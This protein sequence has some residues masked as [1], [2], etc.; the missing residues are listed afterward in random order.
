MRPM[1]LDTNACVSHLSRAIQCPTFGY[2]DQTHGNAQAFFQLQKQLEQDFPRC[3]QTLTYRTV[4]T[5]SRLYRWAGKDGS[6]PP[7]LLMAHQDVVPISPGTQGDWVHPPFSGEIAE[8]CV[9]GRGAIDM[10]NTLIA[11]FE[12]MEYLIGQGFVPEQDV[13]LCTGHDEEIMDV[14]GSMAVAQLCRKEGMH[15]EFVLDE[16]GSFMD[17]AAFGAPGT[18]LASVCVYEKGYC[19]VRLTCQSEGGHSS[20]PAETTALGDM[21]RALNALEQTKFP[22]RATQTLLDL[23]RIL[24]PCCEPQTRRMAQQPEVYGQ[25]LAEQLARSG[26]YGNAMVRTTT[27]VTQIGASEAPNVLP[28]RVWANVNFRLNAGDTVEG[29]RRFVE[30][31]VGPQFEIELPIAWNPTRQARVDARGYRLLAKTLQTF[32]PDAVVA[33]MAFFGGTDSRCFDDLADDVYK[34]MPFV[35]H[36]KYAATMHGTNERIDIDDYLRG[37]AF[38]IRFLESACGA[39]I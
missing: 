34:H 20:R 16:G 11:L 30:R 38:Y 4:N 14:Y 26:P 28:Q 1:D 33:P 25:Q 37:I 18:T 19:D 17:G 15:F 27:A 5:F 36:M 32:Y 23:Y 3:F 7:I 35:S 10:K 9:W 21:A 29:L 31:T 22:I 13:Y 39:Q 2:V 8:G 24:A 6:K 12:A